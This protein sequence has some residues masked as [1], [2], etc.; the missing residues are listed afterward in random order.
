LDRLI[1][2]E[3]ASLLRHLKSFPAYDHETRTHWSLEKEP[4]RAS[5]GARARVG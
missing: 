4:A 5:S 3:E 1:V 2:F